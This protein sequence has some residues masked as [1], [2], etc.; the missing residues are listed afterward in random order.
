MMQ[1]KTMALVGSSTGMQIDLPP[2]SPRPAPLAAGEGPEA[3]LTNE[4]PWRVVSRQTHLLPALASLGVAVV[5]PEMVC[6]YLESHPDMPDVVEDVC[7]D[8]R[9]E[10]GPEASLSLRVYCDPEIEDR[11]LALS[12]RLKSYPPD[13]VRRLHAV[14]DAQ[15]SRL[16][17]K[18]GSILVT[19]DFGPA[20]HGG[21]SGPPARVAEPVRL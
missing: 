19:T 1:N 21:L 9:R 12:V 7:R 5:E 4:S 17:D 20:P 6:S 3:I 18:S 10:F 16:W 2:A 11:Y 15:E 13:V 14:S 8:A